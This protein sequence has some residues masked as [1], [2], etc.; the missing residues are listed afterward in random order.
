MF[1]YLENNI[2]PLLHQHAFIQTNYCLCL[3]KMEYIH[4]SFFHSFHAPINCYTVFKI[5]IIIS[6]QVMHL[7][8]CAMEYR[9]SHKD[10]T[11][12]CF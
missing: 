2:D 10:S 8:Q 6:F 3:C 12:M 7:V 1:S 11:V 9:Y 4:S 5:Y